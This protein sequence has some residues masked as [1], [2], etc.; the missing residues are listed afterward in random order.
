MAFRHGFLAE[1]TFG[2]TAL[3]L[4]CDNIDLNIDV[5]TADVTTFTKTWK[6]NIAGQAGGTVQLSGSWDPTASTGPAALITAKIGA[7]PFEC[8][9]YPGGNATGQ[10]SAT[11]DAVLTS[12]AENSSTS[13]RVTF[14][15][16]LLIDDDVVFA[17][18]GS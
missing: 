7:A 8:V 4:F 14:T 18:V 3:T 11:F 9:Y 16:S 5:D 10:R 17:T 2:G 6:R 1:F 13:D 12:Y 15:A